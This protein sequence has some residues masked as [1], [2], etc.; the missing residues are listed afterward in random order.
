MT[1]MRPEQTQRVEG[2]PELTLEQTILR[3]LGDI[4]ESQTF[5]RVMLLGG[6]YREV[7]H[8][9]KL[10]VLDKTIQLVG[11]HIELCEKRIKILEDDKLER[12]SSMRAAVNTA[13]WIGGIVG[14]VGGALATALVNLAMKH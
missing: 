9:G 2:S 14:T 8:D 4:K 11:T 6:I 10:P 1:L 13:K 12:E 3:E 5:M 7:P